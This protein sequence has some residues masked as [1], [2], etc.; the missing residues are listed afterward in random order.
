MHC[1]LFRSSTASEPAH[2]YARAQIEGPGERASLRQ[3]E[4]QIDPIERTKRQTQNDSIQTKEDI[5]EG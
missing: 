1:A 4:R 2:K 3:Q 5:A